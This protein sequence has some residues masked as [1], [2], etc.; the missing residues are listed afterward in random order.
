MIAARPGG[1][2]PL[3]TAM[4]L[5]VAL[6]LAGA[7]GACSPPRAFEAARLLGAIAAGGGESWLWAATPAPV[8]TVVR[9]GAGGRERS[10][11][12]YRPGEPALAGLVLVPGAAAAGKDDPRLVAFATSLARARFAVLVPDI[13]SLRALRVQ[14]ADAREIAEATVHLAARGAVPPGRPIGIAA[15]SYAV[16]PAVLAVLDWGAPADFILGIGGYHSS[17]AVVAFFTTGYWR[18]GPGAPWRYR[19]PNAYGKWV[20]VLSNV[21]RIEDPRDATTLEAMARR[22]LADLDAVI[23]DLAAGLGAEGRSVYAVLENTDPD[24]VAGLIAALPAAI[25]AEM[26]ALDLSRRDLGALSARLILVHGDDDAIIPPSESRALAA[27][28]GETAELFVIDGF[29]HVEPRFGLIGGWQLWRATYRLL[30]A[31]DAEAGS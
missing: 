25:R 7:L 26:A 12:L 5:A 20:F 28:A 2:T 31:R 27:A 22:K 3:V 21:G 18:D 10:A 16:G 30:E 8:R 14:A 6:V 1:R 9:Y 15:I 24:R 4:V 29:S 17:A 23:A 13:E 19:A 11:D